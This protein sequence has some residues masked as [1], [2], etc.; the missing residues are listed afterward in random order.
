MIIPISCIFSRGSKNLCRTS[1]LRREN[2]ACARAGRLLWVYPGCNSMNCPLCSAPLLFGST[3]CTCG[4]Q[5]AVDSRPLEISYSEALRAWW[6]IYWPTQLVSLV[7]IALF[8]RLII[9]LI[10]A[11]R[12]EN[13]LTASPLESYA[14]L[15][16]AG[17]TLLVGAFCV[18]AFASR[19]LRR[20]YRGFRLVACGASGEF[21]RL[22]WRQRLSLWFFIWWRQYA[23]GLFA[24]LL[25][26]PL[27]MLLGTMKI[28]AAN[29]IAA[30]AG[31]FAVGPIVM[32]MLVGYPLGGF[33]IEARRADPA[34][35]PGQAGAV[36]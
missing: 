8:S 17:F 36:A 14:G 23:G 19:I 29:E 27:N 1:G 30:A 12:K 10:N 26:M 33:Q 2:L 34:A 22:T 24:L 32:K 5:R 7:L 16:N 11:A 6:R 18:W 9:W 13:P 4:L 3:S 15:A 35:N 21:R 28:N 25:A 20:D 31:L